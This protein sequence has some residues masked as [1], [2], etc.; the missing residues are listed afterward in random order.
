MIR[1]QSAGLIWSNFPRPSSLWEPRSWLWACLEKESAHL[2]LQTGKTVSNLQNWAL[3][4]VMIWHVTTHRSHVEGERQVP[5]LQ[6]SVCSHLKY[7]IL[8]EPQ[9]FS[10]GAWANNISFTWKVIG[11]TCVEKLVQFLGVSLVTW[12][13]ARKGNKTRC[14]KNLKTVSNMNRLFENP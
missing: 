9:F 12:A 5:V 13:A 6:F 4:D 8:R 11:T 3:N 2:Y 1:L 7:C 14:K 10:S